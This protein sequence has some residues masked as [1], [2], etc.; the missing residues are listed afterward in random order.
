GIQENNTVKIGPALGTFRMDFY[1]GNSDP[2]LSNGAM[3]ITS[4]GNVGIGYTQPGVKLKV[5]GT[6]LATAFNGD[7]S[8]LTGVVASSIVADSLDFSEFKDTMSLDTTTN[9]TMANGDLNF[10]ANTLVIDSSANMIGI[11]DATPSYSLDVTGTFQ[12]TGNSIIGGDLTITGASTNFRTAI[13]AVDGSGSGIDADL[14]DGQSAPSGTIV[15]TTDTQTLTNKTI[16]GASNTISNIGASSLTIDSLD[17]EQFED[18]LD[19][20]ASTE[21]NLGTYNYS[22]DLNSTGD[23]QIMDASVVQHIF[24]DTGDVRLGES[25]EL[26]VDTSEPGVG[27]GTASPQTNMHLYESTTDTEP[28]FE[29]EQ[30]STG[31]AAMQF[32]IV[33]DAYAVGIDNSDSDLFKISYSSTAGSAVLGTNT[34]MSIDSAGNLAVGTDAV[35]ATMKMVISDDLP[36]LALHNNDADPNDTGEEDEIGGIYFGGTYDGTNYDY[37]AL[38]VSEV[39]G[40]WT[41]S[42]RGADIYFKTQSATSGLLRRMVITAAGNV[43]INDTTPTY[44]LDVNGTI[45]GFTIT[46]SS[47]RRYKENIEPLDSVLDKLMNIRGVF[48]NWIDRESHGDQVNVGFIAQELE[49]YFPEL[50]RT[51]NDG[52]KSV[53][54]GKMTAV[55]V[56]AVK[57]L[58]A[59]NDTLKQVL[60]D[61]DP[62]YSFCTD[63]SL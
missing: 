62:S 39:S 56:E 50:V 47:D 15:G 23:F 42:N 20:D 41:S 30:V 57:E 31:D 35:P 38:I 34:R 63:E 7:G 55:L 21:I 60:C 61:K 46:D 5:N 1:I 49:P 53:T 6:V 28:G 37:G 18:T 26:Y 33:G 45:R 59:Q 9:I 16:S 8:A 52:Y 19:L 48:Y 32:S 51:D 44:K 29:I 12:A 17:F 10:D 14:L 40:D 24:Y 58:K 25:N 27:L 13:K 3:S 54:Y 36:R 22:V 11:N 2:S 4:D 43:G